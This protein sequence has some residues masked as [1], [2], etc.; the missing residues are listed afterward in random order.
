MIEVSDE[1]SPYEWLAQ[2]FDRLTIL[3]KMW[4]A[5]EVAA[6]IRRH[7]IERTAAIAVAPKPRAK[8]MHLHG[9]SLEVAKALVELFGGEETDMTVEFIRGGHS[10]DGFYCWCTD[11][12]ED[13]AEFLGR[14][15]EDS[16]LSS[17][18]TLEDGQ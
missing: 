1:I 5:H 18:A 13:G 3:R 4:P 15:S 12:P 16:Y 2:E 6:I 11:Y 7:D 9:V 8:A 14:A 10:G 17:L